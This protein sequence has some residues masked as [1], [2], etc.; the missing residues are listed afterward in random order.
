MTYLANVIV[1]WHDEIWH[2]KQ[3]PFATMVAID[4]P[5][6]ALSE[7]DDSAVFY[8]FENEAEF[9]QAKQEGDNGFEFRILEEK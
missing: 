3:K 9:E 5:F 8:Y 6:D 7:E 1:Q 2:D 4:E